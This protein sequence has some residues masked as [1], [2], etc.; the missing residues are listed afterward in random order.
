M[1]DAGID[2]DL[3]S[4]AIAAVLRTQALGRRLELLPSCGSTNDRASELARQ[5]AAEGTLVVADQQTGGRGRLGR[6]WHSPAGTNLY[7]SLVLRPDRPPSEV[8][9]ITLLA[10]AAVAG[11]LAAVGIQARLKWPNDVLVQTDAGMR[12]VAGI[13]TEMASERDRVRHVVVGI[14]VNV[15]LTEPPP[16]LE[17]RATSIR[18]VLGRP[19]SRAALLADVLLRFED[20][21]TSFLRH[22][23]SAAVAAWRPFA[24]FGLRCRIDGGEGG[25]FDAE[26]RDVDESGNLIVEADGQRR[27]VVAGDVTV[28]PPSDGDRH[29]SWA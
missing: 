5:G 29:P 16:G 13:L 14:G 20:V 7:V 11:A 26:L 2:E 15:N 1:A 6:R 12:K 17:D 9:P 10:G 8:P 4:D 27:R 25:G 18:L 3:T 21:Y 19:I 23:P 28:L 22:G 24:L